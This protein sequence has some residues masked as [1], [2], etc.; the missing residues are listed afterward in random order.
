MQAFDFYSGV[1]PP[2]MILDGEE[3]VVSIH[4]VGGGQK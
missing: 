3:L 2:C 1:R 4:R